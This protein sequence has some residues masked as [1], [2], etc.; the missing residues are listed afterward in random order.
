ML[1]EPRKSTPI[2]K[3]VALRYDTANDAAPTVI[4]KGERLIA[5]RIIAMAHEHK[6]HI[7]EDPDLVAVLS[8]LAVD[9]PI[10]EEL[11]RAVAEILAFVYRINQRR[12]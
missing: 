3:A 5:E 2:R 9:T 7:H 4:A 8:K 11:Y 1:R 10:P 6:I 12:M